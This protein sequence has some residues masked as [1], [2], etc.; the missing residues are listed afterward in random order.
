[1]DF[2]PARIYALQHKLIC[3]TSCG[4]VDDTSTGRLP[5]TGLLCVWDVHSMPLELNRWSVTHLTVGGSLFICFA[6]RLCD[7]LLWASHICSRLGRALTSLSSW[8]WMAWFSSS[9]SYGGSSET[10]LTGVEVIRPQTGQVVLVPIH[11]SAAQEDCCRLHLCVY[12]TYLIPY[13][14]FPS[15]DGSACMR[16]VERLVTGLEKQGFWNCCFYCPKATLY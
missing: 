16:G 11:H 12:L 15:K 8:F 1:M 10:P 14:A 3:E 13:R 2:L 5:G 9:I 7:R 6:S 4:Q